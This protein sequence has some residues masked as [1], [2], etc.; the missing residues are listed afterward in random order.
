MN[1]TALETF[2]TFGVGVLCLVLGIMALALFFRGLSWI[3]SR[4]M[5][6]EGVAVRGV[7]GKGTWA[8]VHMSGAET[9]E[10]V[11]LIGFTNTESIKNALP[12][13]LSG[14]VILED[15]AGKRFLVRAKA[16]RMIV[17]E[18]AA[19]AGDGGEH[20]GDA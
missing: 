20:A 13:D 5:G 11:R 6:P 15:R 9:F 14:M 3:G 2:G 1:P 12:H 8:T 18:P 7:L 16:I 17:V 10:Q 4:G 19:Q